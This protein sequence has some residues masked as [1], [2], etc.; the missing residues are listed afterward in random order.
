MLGGRTLIE[1][2]VS[3]L[4]DAE[5]SPVIVVV[6]EDELEAAKAGYADSEDI[7]I[8][9]AGPSRQ[10]S[11]RNGLEHVATSRVVVH[12]AASP[13]ATA[14]MVRGVLDGLEEAD[15]VTVGVPL[16]ETVKRV[17]GGVAI[18]TLDRSGLWR[19][20]TPQ[21]FDTKI[22]KRAH[23]EA[24]AA[25]IEA[26]DDAALVE[27]LGLPVRVLPGTRRNI[28]LTYA[29]DFALAEAIIRG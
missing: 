19:V 22:L 6:P 27:R 29:E 4:R 2:S 20:Q 9:R 10:A 7:L 13:L 25:G 11:V 8:A 16:D 26:T 1:W 24:L 14:E 3:L 18:E 5:C 12:D 28:K 23:E 15:A 21:A 17:E